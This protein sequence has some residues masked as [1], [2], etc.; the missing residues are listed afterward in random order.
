MCVLLTTMWTSRHLCPFVKSLPTQSRSALVRGGGGGEPHL[1]KIIY[2]PIKIPASVKHNITS[3]AEVQTD[4]T[5]TRIVQVVRI[6]S[7]L[8]SEHWDRGD[9]GR[10]Q[11]SCHGGF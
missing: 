6:A 3:N 2:M 9:F 10:K 11:A 5:P 4:E 7:P 1:E 8:S